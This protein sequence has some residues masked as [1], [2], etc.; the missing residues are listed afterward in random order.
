MSQS[1]RKVAD[2]KGRFAMAIVNGQSRNQLS[3]D[4]GRIVLTNRRLIVASGDGKR[5]IP[6]GE[7]SNIGGRADVSQDVVTVAK[8]VSI[9][10][11][12]DVLL[13]APDSVEAFEQ[14]LYQVLLNGRTLSIKHPAVKGGVVQDVSWVDGRIKIESEAVAIALASGSLIDIDLA[15]IASIETDQR[16]VDGE[17]SAVIH[18]D[19]TDEGTSVETAIAGQ[20]R[21]IRLFASFLKDRTSDNKVSLDLGKLEREVLMAL[22]SGVSP[23]ELPEF[24]GAEVEAIEDIYDRLIEA[25]VLEEIHVRR[26]VGL[27]ARGRNLASDVMS[28]Q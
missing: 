2:S 8:Y 14:Q 12:D 19:H 1:E 26:E 28:E 22:Y 23:F 3:W 11:D 27:T 21:P 13:V 17:Q 20:L 6:L 25:G 5:V 18:V 16:Q 9:H 10:I 15:D 7:I 24:V 4:Q